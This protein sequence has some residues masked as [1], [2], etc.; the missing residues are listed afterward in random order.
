MT[1]KLDKADVN[2]NVYDSIL[3]DISTVIEA[4]RRSAA[5]SVNSIMTAVYWFIGHR[6]VEFE[7][8]GMTRAQYGEELLKRLSVDLSNR[9]GRGFSR[10]NLQQMRQFYLLYLPEKICQTLSG[11]SEV[12]SNVQTVSAKFDLMSLAACFPLPW[13]AYVRRIRVSGVTIKR[14]QSKISLSPREKGD[15][16]FLIQQTMHQE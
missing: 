6:I 12:Q 7:Q 16:L 14:V 9:Y 5:R 1:K 2:P 11:I 15:R 4:A 3:G 10:Q 13:S 8:V